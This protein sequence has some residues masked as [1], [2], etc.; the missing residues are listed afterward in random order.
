MSA[1]KLLL[2]SL[3][4]ILAA[5]GPVK[6][7]IEHQY[8]LN[9]Y[10]S[11]KVTHLPSSASLLIT[12]TEAVNGYQT[13]EMRY[14]KEAYTLSSFT[15]NNW[16]SPPANMLYSLLIQSFRHCGYFSAISSGNYISKTTYRLDTQ[17]LKL[18][19]NFVKNQASLNSR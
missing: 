12:P 2:I 11:E 17:L 4:C 13:N 5:C 10:S 8:Q 15:K 16:V 3:S 7:P 19:Q 6:N 14:S 1:K 9:A 18:Q